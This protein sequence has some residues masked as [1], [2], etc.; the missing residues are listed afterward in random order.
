MI[1]K[2]LQGLTRPITVAKMFVTEMLMRDLL[3]V[4]NLVVLF[5]RL[6]KSVRQQLVGLLGRQSRGRQP[7]ADWSTLAIHLGFD[8]R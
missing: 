6:S 8:C 3:A 2:F 1:G 5:V 4:T 7:G